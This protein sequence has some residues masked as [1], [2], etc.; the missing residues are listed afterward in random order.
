MSDDSEI[1]ERPE[2]V[3]FMV[4]KMIT[5]DKDAITFYARSQGMKNCEMLTAMLHL[6]EDLMV[7]GKRPEGSSARLLLERH[8]LAHNKPLLPTADDP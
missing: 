6:Y 7:L 2:R 5:D 1:L 3:H 8:G 4:R